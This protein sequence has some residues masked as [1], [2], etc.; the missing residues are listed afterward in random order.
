MKPLDWGKCGA[1]SDVVYVVVLQELG[2]IIRHEG[3]TIISVD[4]ARQPILGDDELL[5]ALGQGMGR[6]GCD[7]VEEGVFAEEIADG[8][9]LFTF[10]V[11]VF[12][13]NPLPWAI[14]DIPGK[15][16]LCR[17]RGFV[18]GADGHW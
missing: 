1:G 3:S 2:E 18:L 4:K 6:Y 9:V 10:V 7:F 14:E 8:Q 13:C 5:Q 16:G 17:G 15:H 12:S 11:D